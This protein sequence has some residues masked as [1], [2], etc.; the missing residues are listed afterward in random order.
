VSLENEGPVNGLAELG[1][2]DHSGLHSL[3]ELVGDPVVDSEGLRLGA[4]ADL[5]IDVGTDR[6]AYAVIELAGPERKGELVA[7]PWG[8]LSVDVIQDLLVLVGDALFGE[9]AFDLGS[10][11]ARPVKGRAR[12]DQVPP[13]DQIPPLT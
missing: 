9:A 5:W 12:D 11:L 7:I 2:D 6:V 4:I 8:Q 13:D 3:E 10:D 1:S